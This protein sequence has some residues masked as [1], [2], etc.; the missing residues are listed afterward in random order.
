MELGVRADIK[1][2]RGCQAVRY[3]VHAFSNRL[4]G[5]VPANAGDVP[6]LSSSDPN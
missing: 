1:I 6:R 2:N 5:C 3:V 4:E